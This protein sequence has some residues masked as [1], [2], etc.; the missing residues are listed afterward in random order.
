MYENGKKQKKKIIRAG[1]VQRCGLRIF[2][3][4]NSGLVMHFYLKVIL[5]LT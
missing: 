4:L 1:I 2:S 5:C 3:L